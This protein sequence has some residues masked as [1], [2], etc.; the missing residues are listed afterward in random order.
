MKHRTQ[1]GI[2]GCSSIAQKS[3]IPS[4]IKSTRAELRM[5]GSRSYTKAKKIASKFSCNQY[6]TY[7]EVLENKKIDAVY[8]SLPIALHEKWVIKSAKKGKHIICEKS[9]TTS[10]QSAKKMAKTCKK[11]NVRLLEGFSFRF[12][13]QHDQVLKIIQ[14]KS[15]GEIFS[16]T[17]MYGFPMSY[18][19]KNFRFK[20]ELG[21]GVL[22]DIGCYLICASRLIFQSKPNSIVCNLYYKKKIGVDMKGSIYMV[23]PNNRIA[24]GIFGYDNAFQAFYNLWGNK[25]SINL[26]RAFNIRKNMYTTIN[27]DTK[28]KTKKIRINPYDQFRLMINEFCKELKFPRSSQFNFENDFITQAYIMDAARKSN[29]KKQIMNLK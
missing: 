9:A 18:S 16:F 7:D 12:H 20:K 25:G 28:N 4:I 6:G 23:Y 2:I 13:P 26:P 24:F 10:Y 1:F 11:N 29:L 3:A 17:G 21:G 14:K 27:L 8:I 19:S 22:N 5:V 15:L